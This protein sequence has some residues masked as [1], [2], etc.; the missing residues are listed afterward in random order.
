MTQRT[1]RVGPITV[2]DMSSGADSWIRCAGDQASY[3]TIMPIRGQI[4]IVDENSSITTASP[5][6]G[7]VCGP[8][9]LLMVPRWQAGVRMLALRIEHH[10]VEDTLS[11]VIGHQVTSPIAVAPFMQTMEGPGRG[12]VQ[13]LLMLS[14]E[15]SQSHSALNQPLVAGPLVESVIRT[16]LLAAGHAHREVLAG[17]SDYL[18]PKTVRTAVQTIEARPDFPLTVSLLAAESHVSERALQL[19]FR[20]HLRMSPMTYLRHVRLRRA[21]EQLLASDPSVDTVAAIAKRWGF[22]NAGRFAAA[23]VAR[24]GESPA[25]ALRRSTAPLATLQGGPR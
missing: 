19:A 20:R 1:G 17:Q 15:L 13:M 11:D 2:F 4:E 9:G 21:H 6:T 16:F 7:A 14:H 24:Y 10:V 23:H 25:S 22:T 5:G 8:Q 3:Q 18:A 12:L